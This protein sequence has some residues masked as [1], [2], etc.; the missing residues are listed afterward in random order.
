MSKNKMSKKQLFSISTMIITV[1]ANISVILVMVWSYRYAN[2]EKTVFF[3]AFGIAVCLLVILDIIFFV[4]YNNKDNLLKKITCVIASVL[5]VAGGLGS[6]YVGKLNSAVNN[7]IEN[8]DGEQYEVIRTVIATYDNNNIKDI[9][10]LDGKVVGSLNT[11]GISAASVGREQIDKSGIK[12]E[13]KD[14][15]MSGDLYE[16]L[17]D[18]DIDAAIFPNTYRSQLL[19]TD[20]GYSEYL[21]KTGDIFS[22]EEKVKTAESESSKKDLSVDPF[23]ILLIGYAPEP[24]G[25]GLTDTIILASVNPAAMEVTMVSIPRDSYVPISCYGGARSKINDAGAASKACLM[26]TV[27]D[28][29]DV[30]VDFYMEVNFQG[31]VDIVDALGGIYINS[32]VEFTGQ[33]SS[34]NRGEYSVWVPAGPYKANGEQAL[35]FARERHAMPGG[36]FDRQIHQQEVISEIAKSLIELRDVNKALSIM[37]VAGENFSTN[38]SLKQLTTVFNYIINASNYTG[39]SQFNMITIKS[40]RITG[41]TYWF[42]NYSCHLPLWSLY[43]Y[44]GSIKDNVSLID[45]TMGEFN[46]INQKPYQK[47][48]AI[49]PY[50]RG[51]LY[52]EYYDEPLVPQDMPVYVLKFTS[53]GYTVDDVREWANS[54]G[55]ALNIEYVQEGDPRYV[56]GAAGLIVD[57]SA[58]YGTLASDLGGSFTIWVCGDI[59]EEDKVPNFVGEN[60]SYVK[61]WAKE[62]GYTLNLTEIKKSDPNYDAKYAGLVTKQSIMAGNNKNK[63]DSI[64][65]EYMEVYTI[66]EYLTELVVERSTK[67][68]VISW[69][70]KYMS[71]SDLCSFNYVETK[72]EKLDGLLAAEPVYGNN[73]GTEG[74]YPTSWIKFN[75]YKFTELEPEPTDTPV[76]TDSPLPTDQ[77]EPTSSTDPSPDPVPSTPVETGNTESG[78]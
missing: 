55:I 10:D 63:Y 26:E 45:E 22:Y 68:D 49:Y 70:N 18:G 75:I 62:N 15:N 16:A 5:L 59:P 78:E 76:P 47:F 29:L 24:G 42:Y 37:E 14:Y 3:G 40:S 56:E 53:G 4:G 7:I 61:K 73:D 43:L 36:D 19:S 58:Q 23:T 32:P 48:F 50:V 35:A 38:L 65:I 20:E 13:Y 77:P 25:G 64:D 44:N 69:C 11:T 57:M 12:V 9:K 2:L 17:V 51:S 30:E 74:L 54:A 39:L 27:G 41:Y 67:D 8:T 31:L 46:E 52:K 1:L 72:D 33:S 34:S 66:N 28:L 6:F 21:D 71:S 60:V